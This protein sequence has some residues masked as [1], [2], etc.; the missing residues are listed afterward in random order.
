MSMTYT[1]CEN[2]GIGGSRFVDITVE[3][4]D[5]TV[6]EGEATLSVSEAI[7]ATSVRFVEIDDA[8]TSNWHNAPERQFVVVLTGVIE[9]E[10]TDGSVRRFGPGDVTLAA[11]VDGKGH[12]ARVV[13]SPARILFIT[14]PAG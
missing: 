14:T 5:A 9:N 8:R 12:R 10:T 11:D 3:Q 13:E 7:P 6:V 4:L 1:V 2:D